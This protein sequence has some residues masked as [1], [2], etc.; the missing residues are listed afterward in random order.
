MD[1]HNNS[2]PTP[3][4]VPTPVALFQPTPETQN[5]YQPVTAF[6]PTSVPNSE[7]SV[8]TVP[9]T[10]AVSPL[11]NPVPSSFVPIQTPHKKSNLLWLWITLGAVF[12]IV[13]IGAVVFFVSKQTADKVADDYTK[14][15]SSYVDKIHTGAEVAANEADAKKAVDTEFS[16]K[17]TLKTTFLSNVSNKYSKA[18]ELQKS[19]ETNVSSFSGGI[20]ELASVYAYVQHNE[21]NY[22]K[23]TKAVNTVQSSSV[24]SIVVGAMEDVL[25]VLKDA[26]TSTEAVL[27]PT[28]LTSAKKDLAAAYK[29]E[30]IQWSALLSARKAKNATAYNTA[31]TGFTNASR[32]ES[33]ALNK[34]NSY[35]FELSTKRNDLL[36]KLDSFKKQITQ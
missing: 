8:P 10:P 25:G 19:V 12:V 7:Q 15:V 5:T 34:I 11:P 33:T 32:A 3:D 1:E 20:A 22:K 30:V 13:V 27:L 9:P 21:D 24:D 36:E 23:I 26:Q 16:N 28:E 18:Q 17:P 35:Y 4:Q 6:T 14:S 31:Y 29:G 2:T